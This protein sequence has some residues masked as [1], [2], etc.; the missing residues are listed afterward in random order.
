MSF[1]DYTQVLTDMRN[2]VEAASLGFKRVFKNA[3]D[4]EFTFMNC[5]LVDLRIRRVVP[6]LVNIPQ[7][8]YSTLVVEAE[9][10]AYDMTSRD[11]CATIRDNLTNALQGYFKA[12]PRFSGWADSTEVGP[13][14]FD[15]G[16]TKQQGEFVAATV[17]T[18]NV[19]I[20][21]P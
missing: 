11:K 13:A 6:E 14:E 20:Q 10:A 12:N 16:E 19:K 18:F 7:G 15:V 8:Y 5:P 1:I 3:D 2:V 17:A 4:Q 9:I 21:S